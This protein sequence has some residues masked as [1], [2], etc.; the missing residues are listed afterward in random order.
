LRPGTELI[1]HGARSRLN[2]RAIESAARRL[3][4]AGDALRN[5]EAFVIEAHELSPA[6][7]H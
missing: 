6:G 5:D 4:R 3:S 7:R 1:L 2:K